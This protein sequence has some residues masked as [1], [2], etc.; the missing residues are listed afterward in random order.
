M[1]KKAQTKDLR[2]LIVDDSAATRSF[3]ISILESIDGCSVTATAN[4]FE[5]LKVLPRGDFDLI[6]TDI[7]MPDINGLELIN[8][9]KKMPS[10][11]DVPLFIISTEG[12]ERDRTKGLSLGADEY[13]VKP[14]SPDSLETLVRKHL[15]KE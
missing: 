1:S 5:A 7:N 3:V 12:A 11:K 2:I 8:Y 15:F 14:F 10:Y 6:I 9:V 4:G 13:L